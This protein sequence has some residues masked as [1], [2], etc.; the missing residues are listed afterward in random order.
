M[1]HSTS[2]SV[3]P[4]RLRA[5]GAAASALL[6]GIA[7]SVRLRFGQQSAAVSGLSLSSGKGDGPPDLDELW[8]DFN[9]KPPESTLHS[10][11]HEPLDL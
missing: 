4:A 1:S 3:G 11:D 2:D 8:R 6:A 7:T 5:T 9:R 10:H